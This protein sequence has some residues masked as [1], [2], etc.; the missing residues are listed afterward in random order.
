MVMRMAVHDAN[1]TQ[2]N[3]TSVRGISLDIQWLLLFIRSMD[4]WNSYRWKWPVGGLWT[5]ESVQWETNYMA[6]NNKIEA[7][8]GWIARLVAFVAEIVLGI[9]EKCAGDVEPNVTVAGQDGHGAEWR[10]LVAVCLAGHCL[11][12]KAN[13]P[14]REQPNRN[15]ARKRGRLVTKRLP[16]LLQLVLPLDKIEICCCHPKRVATVVG[17]DQSCD[18]WWCDCYFHPKRRPPCWRPALFEWLHSTVGGLPFPASHCRATDCFANLDSVVSKPVVASIS[19]MQRQSLEY[20]RK[21][22]YNTT[23]D[24]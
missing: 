19:P 21:D 4:K 13:R 7:E 17:W 6:K 15:A 1:Y 22:R 14:E 5:D 18:G 12:C 16:M 8:Q 3:V 24:N 10:R 2:T 11:G 20:N 9:R 23:E